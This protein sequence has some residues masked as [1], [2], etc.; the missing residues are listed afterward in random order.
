M[1]KGFLLTALLIGGCTLGPRYE[2]PEAPIPSGWKQELGHGEPFSFENWWDVFE[3]EALAELE[4]K[5]VDCNPDLYA[6]MER[7][8]TA[9]AIAGVSKSDLY[10]QIDLKPNYNN[11]EQLIQLYGIPTGDFP[12]LKPVVR[13]HETSYILPLTMNY[14]IDLWGKF[15]GRYNSALLE[16]ESE[17]EAFRGSLLTLTSELASN[18]FN[19]RTLDTELEFMHQIVNLRKQALGLSQ[20]RFDAGLVDLSEVQNAT[21]SLSQ[22]EA[23]YE[24]LKRQR[25]L[26]EN[27]IA[28]LIGSPASNIQLHS[29]P[30]RGA[31]PS[32][33]A[34]IPSS[35]LIQRPDIARV[36]RKMA[37][38]HALI[39][40]AYSSFF[41]SFSLS[42]A[43]GSFSTQLRDF[44]TWKS[45]LWQIG[46][47]IAQ[48][49][50]DGWKRSSELDAAWARFRET[51]GD[52]LKTVLMAFQETEDALNNL[53]RQREAQEK[54]RQSVDAAKSN[55]NLSDKRYKEGL[56][57][58]LEVIESKRIELNSLRQEAN[59]L[60]LRYQS[61]VQLIKALGGRWQAPSFE[62]AAEEKIGSGESEEG[63]DG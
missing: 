52:Y 61:T 50:F 17:E 43:L 26:F 12:G 35:V 3:D 16:A 56:A 49:I 33:P 55:W 13:V 29:L 24:D 30:L 39:G 31:P 36:E 32:I 40:V 19:M 53:D 46:V 1:K 60:G 14:E 22:D 23:E 9:R 5:A 25:T 2:L 63:N 18:Y 10:P 15:R 11:L 34:G 42:G 59:V 21:L 28:A 20:L 47:N 27:A 48:T 41:P 7:V 6:A 57:N 51:Q 44:L 62:A 45:R 37:S 58:L 54:L 38:V 4:Q 8:V